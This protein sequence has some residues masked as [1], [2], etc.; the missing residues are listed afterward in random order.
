[1]SYYRRQRSIYSRLAVPV[2]FAVLFACIF[3]LVS[4]RSRTISMEYR[5][6]HLE[7]EKAEALKEEKTLYAQ[8]SSLLSIQEVAKVDSGLQFPDRQ[9]VVYVRR[10]KG[11]VPYKASLRTE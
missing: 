11:D 9:R 2:L 3:G 10:D 6:G 1:M 4:L 5:I 7:R 8:M